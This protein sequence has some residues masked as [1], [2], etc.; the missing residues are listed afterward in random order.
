MNRLIWTAALILSTAAGAAEGGTVKTKTPAQAV[1]A[2]L[3][4]TPPKG[5]SVVEY[6]NAGGAD[7]VV[8]FEDLSDAVQIRLFGAPGS[9]Y[10]TPK[11]FLAGP[12]ASEQGAAAADAGTAAVAGKK[13]KL[14]RRRFPIEAADPHRP[15]PGSSIMGTE[16]FCV[17]P[18]KGGRFAVLAYRRAS[19]IP[20]LHRKGEKAWEAF[21]KTVK[22]R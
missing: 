6:A 11:D 10:P 7:P 21:L 14:H 8:R 13:L 1:A 16:T 3:S 18:L 17:L 5:W 9:D 2:L 19:P 20:D 12:A 15:S 4:F 22:P